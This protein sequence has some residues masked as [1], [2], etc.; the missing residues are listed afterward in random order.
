MRLEGI[1]G[2]ARARRQLEDEMASGRL[3]HAYLFVGPAGTGRGTVARSL[4]QALN[5]EK[6]AETACGTC[7]TCRRSRA[8][9]HEDLLVVAPPAE[10]ASPQIKVE[11]VREVIRQLSFA[12]YAGGTRLVLIRRAEHLNPFSANALLKTL[13]E[14]PPHN[15]LVLTV[16][17]PREL[18]PTLVSRCRRVKFFPLPEE[19]VAGE[20][21]ARGAAPEEARLRAGLAGGSLGHALELDQVDL[22]QR[23]AEVLA[24]LE[25][26][27]GAL[28]AWA[29]AEDLVSRFR[30]GK[31]IDREGI[32]ETLDLLGLALRDQAVALAGRPDLRVLDASPA[33]LPATGLPAVLQGFDLVRRAQAMIAGNAAPELTITVLLLSLG[34]LLRPAA[35]ARR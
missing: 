29:R 27:G 34:R 22:A 13:E 23:L 16:Q 9:Q 30:G 25:P 32:L 28:A 35:A 5:C 20:L 18:L 11:E 10:G 2:Q 12:P 31:V 7:P 19:Q 3:A 26:T 33:A 1:V 8:W 14:P 15:I 24:A 17:D 21:A 6:P 4:F